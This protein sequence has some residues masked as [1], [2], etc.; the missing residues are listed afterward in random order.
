[1]DK[2]QKLFD[3]L[4]LNGKFMVC[5]TMLDTSGTLQHKFLRMNFPEEDMLNSIVEYKKLAVK[6]M[7]KKEAIEEKQK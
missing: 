4:K 5:T 1:M 3:E 7:D 6:E 2:L